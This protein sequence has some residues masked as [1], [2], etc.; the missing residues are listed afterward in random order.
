MRCLE[1]TP[2]ASVCLGPAGAPFYRYNRTFLPQPQGH[3]MSPFSKLACYVEI[4]S[5][6]QPHA[7]TRHHRFL[8]FQF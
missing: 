1:V 7:Q 6:N 4:H 2:L 3:N 5:N 8:M